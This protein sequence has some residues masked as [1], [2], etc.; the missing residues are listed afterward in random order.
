M[1]LLAFF[2]NKNILQ[3][4]LKGN[5]L[6]NVEEL[7]FSEIVELN[8]GDYAWYDLY[9]EFDCLTWLK[10]CAADNNSGN[11]LPIPKGQSL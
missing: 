10:G 8:E 9:G 11:P 4:S 3:T 1:Y 7:E 2:L 5:F 6:M